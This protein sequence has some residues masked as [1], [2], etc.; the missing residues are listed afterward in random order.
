M[1]KFINAFHQG[2]LFAASSSSAS[3]S[4]SVID[5][6]GSFT[7]GSL[8]GVPNDSCRNDLFLACSN[9]TESFKLSAS[10]LL[11]IND[12]AKA[13]IQHLKIQE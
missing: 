3:S 1:I 7:S 12:H 13:L 6:G 11:L 8:R 10:L 4:S 2:D 9:L 5:T